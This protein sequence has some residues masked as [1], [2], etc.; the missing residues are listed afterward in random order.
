[1]RGLHN[2][3]IAP[4]QF[5]KPNFTHPPTT[6]TAVYGNFPPQIALTPVK[7]QG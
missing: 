7:N 2:L 1:M 3:N 6:I 5:F 4:K